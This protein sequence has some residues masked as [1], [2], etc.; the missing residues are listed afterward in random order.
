MKIII[1][2][3]PVIHAGYESFLLKHQ[4]QKLYLLGRSITEEFPRMERDIRALTPDRILTALKAYSWTQEI[5]VL[6]KEDVEKISSAEVLMPDEDLSR[7]FAETYLKDGRAE[8]DTAFLR[9]DMPRSLSALPPEPEKTVSLSILDKNFMNEA[10]GEARKSSDWWRQIGAVVVK[11][12]KVVFNAHN[13]HMP[14]EHSPY[15]VG[16]PRSNFD[17]GQAPDV[18]SSIHAEAGIIAQAARESLHGADIYVTTFP[19]ANCA[20]VIAVTGIKRL[21]YSEGYSRLEGSEIMKNAGIEIVHVPL[22]KK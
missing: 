11:D 6:E 4:P 3:I 18:Y 9:Y 13:R 1:A 10:V 19:C 2:Y 15:I 16:D 20:R 5:E 7:W 17:A 21:F 8:Y 12:G 14:S 22:E